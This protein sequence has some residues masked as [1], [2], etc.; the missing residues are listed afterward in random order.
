MKTIILFI[1]TIFF[2]FGLWTID[3]GVS[4]ILVNGEII[5]LV[6]KRDCIDHYHLGLFFV[7]ISFLIL[8]IICFYQ[9]NYQNAQTTQK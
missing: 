3:I 7:F 4:C 6:G 2:M 8:L 1:I 5:T 9:S